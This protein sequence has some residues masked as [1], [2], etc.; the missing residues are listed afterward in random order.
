MAE[1]SSALAALPPCLFLG[2]IPSH[3]ARTEKKKRAHGE[4]PTQRTGAERAAACRG[5]HGRPHA[6]RNARAARAARHGAGEGPLGLARAAAFERSLCT[7]QARGLTT[8]PFGSSPSALGRD[9][10]EE[11]FAQRCRV[12]ACGG[13][14]A[15]FQWHACDFNTDDLIGP[16]ASRCSPKV[17]PLQE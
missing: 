10:A 4:R 5:H 9:E 16:R 2:G 8:A 12:R 11:E 7:A 13:A 17:P 6:R 3:A 1:Q 14:T 15:R